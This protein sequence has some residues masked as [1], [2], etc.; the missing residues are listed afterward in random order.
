[1][2]FSEYIFVRTCS[3]DDH[4][5]KQYNHEGGM[6]C[7]CGC[8]LLRR[9]VVNGGWGIVLALLRVGAEVQ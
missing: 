3:L 1:V 5:G 8:S 4:L 2:L 6:G 9:C 7:S